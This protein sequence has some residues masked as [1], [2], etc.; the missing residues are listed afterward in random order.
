M[1]VSWA[2]HLWISWQLKIKHDSSVVLIV[3]DS[4]SFVSSIAFTLE[5]S[6]NTFCVHPPSSGCIT[7]FKLEPHC[8]VKNRV[9]KLNWFFFKHFILA[10]SPCIFCTMCP[11]LF[12]SQLECYQSITT[13]DPVSYTDRINNTVISKLQ[14][15]CVSGMYSAW[16]NYQ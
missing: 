13:Q 9:G 5:F 16:D 12:Y 4:T 11:I 10:T 8:L 1:F 6:S 15:G 3:L 14:L 2:G 7:W